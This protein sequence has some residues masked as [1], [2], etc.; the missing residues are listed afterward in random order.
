MIVASLVMALASADL[1]TGYA[2]DPVLERRCAR[3]A[4]RL[5]PGVGV[6]RDT[7]APERP[8][9]AEHVRITTLNLGFLRVARRYTVP[10]AASRR[11]ELPAQL[12]AYLQ[13]QRPTV[14]LF[15]ECYRREDREL[16]ASIGEASGYVSR[17]AGPEAGFRSGLVMLVRNDAGAV[18][19]EGFEPLPGDLFRFAGYRRGVMWLQLRT[20]SGAELIVT[21]LHLTPIHSRQLSWRRSV[22]VAA[23]VAWLREGGAPLAC[24]S[25]PSPCTLVLAG[26]FNLAPAHDFR[27]ALQPAIDPADLQRWLTWDTTLYGLLLAELHSEAESLQPHIWTLDPANPTWQ[28]YP[29]NASLPGM[30]PDLAF[31]GGAGRGVG[32]RRV[33]DVLGTVS[34]LPPSDHYGLELD[35]A[36]PG[37]AG[38]DR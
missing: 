9:V 14:V 17:S 7:I 4:R 25:A 22:Q 18:E 13:A 8:G 24:L 19:G 38:A 26:D 32:A 36:L 5:P 30:R 27:L 35:L 31:V 28:G 29:L 12:G 3:L 34:G 33:L 21:N 37:L 6:S 15:Q 23:L 11:A 16:V 1:C 2:A 10:G 20:A